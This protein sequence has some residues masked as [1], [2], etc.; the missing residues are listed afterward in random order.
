M[1]SLYSTELVADFDASSEVVRPSMFE[2][3]FALTKARLSLMVVFTTA[4]GYFLGMGAKW[5][6]GGLL[7]SVIGTALAA[8]SAA[9]LNQVAE[10]EVDR[11]MDRTKNRP[12]PKGRIRRRH[13]LA[14]GMLLAVCGVGELWVLCS[15]QSALIALSTIVIYLLVY[16]P[17]KRRSA[18]CTAVGAVSG[19]LPPVIGWAASD[20]Y[21]W[22]IPLVL[23]GI[24]F[25]WQIPH[26]L[27]IAWMYKDEYEGAGFVMLFPGDRNGVWTAVQAFVTS[28]LLLLVTL[29]PFWTGKVS[30][31]YGSG[32]GLLNLLFV[33][34][35]L[36]FLLE[37]SRVA[38]RR[39]F[40]SSIIF[41]PG[42]LLLLVF[43][44]SA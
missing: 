2:D 22:W 6:W 17:M 41:L 19:A 39:L 25:F 3:L 27:A 13:A 42:V 5:G 1:R 24:L 21:E 43:S 40:F 44:H 36:V 31:F 20:S 37:R 29:V 34:S 38:A 33:G 32:I 30:W 35:A 8:A 16:T 23:F 10:F 7:S 12:L 4:A 18:F 15:P 26:F 14:I 11:L 9:V 28:L